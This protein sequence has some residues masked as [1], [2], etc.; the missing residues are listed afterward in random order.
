MHDWKDIRLRY[1]KLVFAAVYRILKHHDQAL[2]C[3]QE[4]WLTVYQQFEHLEVRNWP[5]LLRWM[6]VKRSLDRL[7]RER[8]RSARIEPEFQIDQLVGPQPSVSEDVEFRE[9]VD[10]LRLEVARLPERQA[11]AFWLHC[12]EQLSTSEVAEQLG[13]DT[14]SIRVLVHRARTRLK[15]SLADVNP[16]NREA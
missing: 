2:D 14:N 16:A 1:G 13:T 3:Y 12:V 6:G 9:L 10:R 4:V 5:A 7:R 11:E 8:R 15:E